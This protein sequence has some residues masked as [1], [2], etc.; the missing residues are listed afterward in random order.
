MTI[1]GGMDRLEPKQRLFVAVSLPQEIK[2]FVN[3][4][5]EEL[6]TELP[7][8]KWMHPE[9]LHVTVKF[10][11]ETET[12]NLALIR[13]ALLPAAAAAP[14]LRLK[15]TSL[16]IFGKP[17]LP[18]LLWAG[19]AGDTEELTT[20]QSRVEDAMEPLGFAKEDRAY[21]PHLTLARR[22]CGSSGRQYGELNRL[23]PHDGF[24]PEWAA[25]ALTVY[26]SRLNHRPMYD[27]LMTIPFHELK[28]ATAR[29]LEEL[30]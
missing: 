23:K 22:G 12:E 24:Q 6:K 18:S 8:Q 9:D 1:E 11:G 14:A 15:L 30:N 17:A 13:Q 21:K 28:N 26:R 20:L 16:G 10:L 27:L 2:T 29:E 7:F 25:N 4:W 5:M 3:E 19:I